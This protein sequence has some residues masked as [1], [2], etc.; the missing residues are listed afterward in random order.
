[1]TIGETKNPL[2]HGAEQSFSTPI[3]IYRKLMI[4]ARRSS[5]SDHFYLDINIKIPFG[6][7]ENLVGP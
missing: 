5:P 7:R 4:P 2:Q 6:M 1:M 3:V